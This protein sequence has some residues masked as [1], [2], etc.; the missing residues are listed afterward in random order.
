MEHCCSIFFAVAEVVEHCCSIFFAVAEVVEHCCSIFF[1]VAE[2]VEHCCSI[3]FA[4]AEVVEHCCSITTLQLGETMS[5]ISKDMDTF[6]FRLPIG[7]VAGITPFNFPA[8]IPLWVNS[9][10]FFHYTNSV[11]TGSVFFF[12]G[13]ILAGSVT[14]QLGLG[15]EVS[16]SVGEILA[17]SV[18]RQLGLGLEVSFSV[19]KY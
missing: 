7:V 11:G 5:G 6:T 1:A 19:G 3:F 12:V 15:L 17:G 13:E 9:F 8:M 2:V 14:R 4:V 18:T 16:F 10:T